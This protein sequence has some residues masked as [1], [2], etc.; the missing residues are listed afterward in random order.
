MRKIMRRPAGR[1]KETR[2]ATEE[3]LEEIKEQGH[4]DD[5]DTTEGRDRGPGDPITPS[6]RANR[7]ATEV[8]GSD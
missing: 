7:E 8:G 1:Q 4:E 6:T 5:T 3:A 2:T